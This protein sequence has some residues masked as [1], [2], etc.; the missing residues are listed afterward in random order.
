[1]SPHLYFL[2]VVVYL[3]GDMDMHGTPLSWFLQP[4]DKNKNITIQSMTADHILKS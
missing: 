2:L 4:H 1:M 3:P